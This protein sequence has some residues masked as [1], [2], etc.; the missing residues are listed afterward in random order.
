VTP[1]V[2]E[3]PG[4]RRQR[5]KLTDKVALVTGA[6][7]GIGRAIATLFAE[8]GARVIANDVN[9]KAARE[10]VE[11]LG[12]ARSGARAI[13][14]DVADSGQVKAMFA[15]VEREFGSLDV[16]VNNAGIGS[17]GT[18]AADRDRLRER[19][20]TRIMELVSGQGIQTHWDI[21]QT[22]TDE[23][24]HRMIAVHLNGTFFCTREALRLMSRRDQGVIIN[25][26]S[27]A[28]LM[29]LENVPHYSAAKAGILG[30]T[31]AVAREVGSR[32]IR[33]N[34][35]CPGFIDTPMTQPMSDLMRK[36]VIGRTPLGRYAEP[37]EVAQTA[38]FLASDDSSFFTGQWLSPNGGLFIG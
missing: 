35:I 38:L 12:A 37:G 3:T 15:E 21:T 9:E 16:L 29:G 20:D 18:S 34:A 33:V 19:S 7:S 17:A 1:G 24:W 8:E 4:A 36:A 26:S 5:V 14:A 13:Q 25:L 23:T 27:V 2:D 28:G 32:K 30:F 11:A 10:T 22:M 6:G 31:R